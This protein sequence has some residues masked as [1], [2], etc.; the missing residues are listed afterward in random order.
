MAVELASSQA[1][2]VMMRNTITVNIEDIQA[3]EL[4]CN[5]GGFISHPVKI[6]LAEMVRCPSCGET[7][8]HSDS[9][10]GKVTSIHKLVQALSHWRDNSDKP[11]NVTF[12]I[13]AE[14]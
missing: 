9:E 7:L 3:I 11:C 10:H 5:C 6:N 2:G 4:H 12:T 13:D 1:Q 14:S 8:L